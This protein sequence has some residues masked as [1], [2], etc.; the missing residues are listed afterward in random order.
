MA[1][2]QEE[3]QWPNGIYQWGENDQITGGPEGTDNVPPR[4]LAGRTQFLAIAQLIMGD[5]AAL[6]YKEA[7][8]NVRQRMQEGTVTIYNRGVILG[9]TASKAANNRKVVIA[10]GG[11]FAQGR[12]ISYA[13]DQTG[14][15]VPENAGSATLTY[16]GY[17]SVAANGSITFLITGA[18]EPVPP[19]GISICR[20]QV[21]TGNTAVD[22]SGVTLTDTRRTEA[23]YPVLIN[24]VPYA[25][26][27]LPY[28]VI[29]ANYAVYIDVMSLSGLL[30]RETVYA[31][32]RASNG[33]KIFVEG[34]I[35]AVSVK[36]LAVKLSL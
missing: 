16:Y 9:C 2:L 1:D 13:G 21:P 22:L 3:Y 32:E 17:L 10:A 4:Q 7:V 29:D 36:W 30:Q 19:G 25:S 24:S 33:F 12:Q 31:G 26:V 23:N 27:A 34:S 11:V 15:T 20:I 8:K 5:V 18:G 6:G 14:I 28:S 35:D